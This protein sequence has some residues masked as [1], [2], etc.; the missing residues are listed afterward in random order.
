MMSVWNKIKRPLEFLLWVGILG[1]A[2]FRLGPQVTA[3][4]GM[5]GGDE[6][7]TMT[8]FRALDG[9][10]LTREDLAGKVVL[11]NAWAT[12]CTPCVIEMPGFQR[13]YEDYR[14]QGF[15][16]LGVSRDQSDAARVRAFLEKKRITYPVAM[17][18]DVD[19]GGITDVQILPTSYLIGRDG[20]IRHKVEGLYAGPA[21][22][23][24]VRRLLAEG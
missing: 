10:D 4:L 19:L 2:S 17:A 23:L 15:L 21:L 18:N 12:W 16:V 5:G 1:F 24:A 3:A 7:F 20:T 14:D 13:V 6:E 11:V 9:S 8:A 22:R